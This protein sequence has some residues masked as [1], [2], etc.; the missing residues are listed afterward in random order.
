MIFDVSY[1]YVPGLSCVPFFLRFLI[2]PFIL[3][4]FKKKGSR[5]SKK[6]H[7]ESSRYIDWYIFDIY[8]ILVVGR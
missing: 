5:E 8:L 2:W 4:L 6:V 3:V 7:E 1:L